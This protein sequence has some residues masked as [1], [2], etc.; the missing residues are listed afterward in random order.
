MSDC[1]LPYFPGFNYDKDYYMSSSF[2]SRY[3]D[4]EINRLKN[5]SSDTEFYYLA[6][7]GYASPAKYKGKPIYYKRTA[8]LG[9]GSH[10]I[11]PVTIDTMNTFINDKSFN[12]EGWLETNEF[13]VVNDIGRNSMIFKKACQTSY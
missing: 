13:W 12:K 10:D 6:R 11:S 3:I 2:Y 4:D 8:F 7:N 5:G 9:S 1:E